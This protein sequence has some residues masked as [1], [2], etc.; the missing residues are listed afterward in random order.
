MGCEG[1]LMKPGQAVD[2]E[3]TYDLPG[4]FVSHVTR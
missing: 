2:V 3:A 1:M 4:S